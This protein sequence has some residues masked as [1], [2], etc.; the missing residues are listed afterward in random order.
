M[1]GFLYHQRL[2]AGVTLY[3]VTSQHYVKGLF[4]Y[5]ALVYKDSFTSPKRRKFKEIVFRSKFKV[6]ENQTTVKQLFLL[7]V[8]STE[9]MAQ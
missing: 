8:P 9:K 1:L 4:V 6:T 2:R 5:W 3:N 7:D